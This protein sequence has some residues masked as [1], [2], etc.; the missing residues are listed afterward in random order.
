MLCPKRKISKSGYGVRAI[1]LSK[2]AAVNSVGG[3]Q[4]FRG[5]R[6]SERDYLFCAQIGVVLLRLN[7]NHFWGISTSFPLD[8]VCVRSRENRTPFDS[9]LTEVIMNRVRQLLR[10]IAALALLPACL[11]FPC[12]PQFNAV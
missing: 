12:A 7:F 9:S 5:L 2:R 1:A 3:T 6:G 11:R 4:H 8:S 10:T